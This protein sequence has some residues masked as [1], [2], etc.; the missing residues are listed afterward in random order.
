MPRINIMNFDNDENERKPYQDDN[1]M[2]IDDNDIILDKKPKNSRVKSQKA[3]NKRKS[4]NKQVPANKQVSSNRQAQTNSRPSQSERQRQPRQSGG[5]APK[6]PKKNSMF[7]KFMKSFAITLAVC[8]LFLGAS[9]Y[10]YNKIFPN[11]ILSE[12]DNT[13]A[14]YV[15]TTS[16]KL[17]EQYNFA[18]FGVDNESPVDPRTDFMMIGSY[19]TKTNQLKLMSIPR[20]TKVIMPQERI[21][22]LRAHD[23][24]ILFPESG[25]MKLNEVNH[26]ATDEYGTSFLL[27][28][29]EEMFEIDFDF[30]LKFNVEAFRYV[31]DAIGGVPFDV[32]QRMYYND[33][34]QDLYIDLQPGYQV[35]DGKEA[36]GL[37]RYRKAD[38]QNPISAGYARGDLD[39]QKVQQDFIEAFIKQLTSVSNLG[40]TLPAI[41]SA[42]SKYC[43]TNFKVTDLPDFLPFITDFNTDNITFYSMPNEPSGNFVV[44]VYP[45]TT[46]MIDEIFYSDE[47]IVPAVSSQGLEIEVLNGTTTPKLASKTAAELEE[48][49]FVISNIGDS[50]DKQEQTKIYV[51]ERGYGQDLQPYFNNAKIV[52]DPGQEVDIKIVVGNDEVSSDN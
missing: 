1:D 44:P 20:D 7:R 47:L 40:K 36:E 42:T 37:V 24:P 45:D 15:D 51:K 21:D 22:F 4:T 31:V 33:P 8:F 38:L 12:F 19:N 48:A 30:Y 25:K 52:N 9:V 16:S 28:Q 32:P 2:L 49:G 34:T 18:I 13:N 27:A 5:N 6:P 23:V 39:R 10:A 29:L 26:F 14:K 43:E 41:I 46:E 50:E 35:L 17:K 3:D 11:S